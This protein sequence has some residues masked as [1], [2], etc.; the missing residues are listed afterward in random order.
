MR[1]IL[2]QEVTSVEGFKMWSYVFFFSSL[3]LF[4]SRDE[5]SDKI[6]NLYNIKISLNQLMAK[7]HTY[8]PHTHIY[9]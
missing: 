1:N 9:I 8:T 4:R 3:S 6:V 5:L 2:L 7:M